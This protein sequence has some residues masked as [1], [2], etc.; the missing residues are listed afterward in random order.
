L[1]HTPIQKY[2][3]VNEQKLTQMFTYLIA[4]KP[5]MS[6]DHVVPGAKARSDADRV[7][8]DQAEGA[9]GQGEG[10]HQD[11]SKINLFLSL[12]PNFFCMFYLSC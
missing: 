5:E 3:K 9:R 10:T 2:H 8:A 4:V 6:H 7:P 1:G 11:I 12:F